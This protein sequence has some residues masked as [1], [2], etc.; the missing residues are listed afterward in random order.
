MKKLSFIALIALM[1]SFTA[2]QPS[3]YEKDF[4]FTSLE[5]KEMSLNQFKG[6]KVL[7][8]NTASKCGYTK[9]YKD[10]QEL[11][12]TYGDKVVIIGM[13]CNQFGGQEPGAEKEIKTFCEKNYGVEFLMSSKIDVKGSNQSDIYKWLTS[14][15]MNGLEDSSVGWNFQKYL[16]NENGELMGHFSS[17]VNPM[18]KKITDL[19]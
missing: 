2:T 3:I 4:K 16:L 6:K 10:L 14:K 5:G 11:H 13:P 8:V 12:K 19:L 18:S 9:Q 7:I 17:S 1:M 15:S